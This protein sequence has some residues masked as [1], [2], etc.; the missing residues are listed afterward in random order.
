MALQ[1]R[2]NHL[3]CKIP[4]QICQMSSLIILDVAHNAI[5]GHIPTCLPNINTLLFNNVSRNKLSFYFPSFR[6]RYFVNKDN[7]ELVTKGEVLDY[8][9]NLHN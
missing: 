6:N 7:L 1:L 4:P 5:S 9:K 8:E 3:S 2:S